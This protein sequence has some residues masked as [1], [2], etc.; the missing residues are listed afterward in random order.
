MAQDQIHFDLLTQSEWRD[1]ADLRMTDCAHAGLCSA[2]IAHHHP[3]IR[4]RFMTT[5]NSDSQIMAIASPSRTSTREFRRCRISSVRKEIAMQLRCRV[6]DL[7]LVIRDGK[8]CKANIA[9][10][11]RLADPIEGN[12]SQQLWWS[13][14]PT[15]ETRKR[16]FTI[17]SHVEPPNDRLL[18]VD[19]DM[20]HPNEVAEVPLL[21]GQQEKSYGVSA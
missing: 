19:L 10:L 2:S 5:C 4:R 1:P 15:G 8:D 12:L 13:V 18:P 14:S 6:V 9:K 21:Q 16:R 7:A 11:V 20:W 3:S 17:A